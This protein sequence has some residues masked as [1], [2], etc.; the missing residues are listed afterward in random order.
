MINDELIASIVYGNEKD[1]IKVKKLNLDGVLESE[2]Y[3]KLLEHHE[4]ETSF[5]IGVCKKL[6]EQLDDIRILEEPL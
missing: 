1:W 6:A 5:L 2:A 3:S 4:K